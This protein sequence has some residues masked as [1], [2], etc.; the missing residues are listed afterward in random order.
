[1]ILAGTTDER[2]Q[3]HSQATYVG[4]RTPEDGR[5]DWE[6]PAQTLHNLVRAVSDP[7]PGAFGYAGANKFIVWKSR[8]RHDLPA[9][10]PGTVLSIAPLIVACQDGALE[11]VTGQT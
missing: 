4:R 10:K 11:I 3:D 1:A 7:W 2:P 9:A 6:L 8:V 5:L